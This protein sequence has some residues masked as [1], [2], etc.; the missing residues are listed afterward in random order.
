MTQMKERNLLVYSIA[1]SMLSIVITIF[2]N[3]EIANEY[4][5][6]H[7]KTRAL[8]GM[9]EMLQFGYQY[10]VALLGATSLILSL[11]S[12]RSNV[13]KEQKYAAI[14]LSLF[15]LTVVFIR[16]WRLFI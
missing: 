4:S 11:L 5:R 15:S 16:I 2:I 8:F 14:A 1:L 13:K 7:G 12:L 6:S 10:Y 9:N 3:I